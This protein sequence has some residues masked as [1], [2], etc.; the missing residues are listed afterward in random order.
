V[1]PAHKENIENIRVTFISKKHASDWAVNKDRGY[2]RKCT[3]VAKYGYFNDNRFFLAGNPEHKNMDFASGV[4]DPTYFPSDGWTKIGSDATAI[5]GYLHYGDSLAIIKEDNER[6]ATVYMRTASLTDDGDI[7]F[8]VQQG[9]Q[10]FGAISKH[11]I[12]SLRDD[13]MFLAKEGV[14][15]IEGT[16]TSQERNVVNRSFYIDSKLKMEAT[17]DAVACE[18]GDYMLLCMP[19]IG[20]CYVA[21]ARSVDGK[22]GSYIYNWYVWNNIPATIMRV[23]GD[24]LYFGTHDGR[25]CVFNTDWEGIDKYSDGAV[26]DSSSSSAIPYK[27]G[28]K[29]RAFYTTKRDH[30]G[31]VDY[32]KTMLNDGGVILLVP[33]EQSSAQISVKTEKGEWFVDDIQTDSDEPSVV[34]PIKKRMKYFDSIQTTVENDRINEGLAI[35]GIQ[36][37]YAITTNRREA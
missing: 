6:D 21:D 35:L 30:L 24:R 34:I 17:N 2:I 28:V 26:Y 25:L 32:K 16:D 19:S 27:D 33:Y 4:D 31:A 10:G 7:I 20:K 5:M 8:P 9:Q 29:I 11:A 22:D 1:V 18:W 37:R 3:V 12:C 23:V 13:P 36:Y 15:A 14:Y